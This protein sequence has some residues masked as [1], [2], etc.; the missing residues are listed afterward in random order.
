MLAR[1][2]ELRQNGRIAVASAGA[3][4]SRRQRDQD[5]RLDLPSIGPQTIEGAARPPAFAGIAVVAGSTIVAEP[6]RIGATADARGCSSSACASRRPG[7]D[8]TAR[9]RLNS[10]FSS[11]PRSG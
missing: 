1:I 10:S 4:W 11:P 2:A 9:I 3:Y 5:R 7:D 6:E 8:R